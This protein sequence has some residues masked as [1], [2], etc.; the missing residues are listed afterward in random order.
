MWA[1]PS[2]DV[3]KYNVLVLHVKADAAVAD[4]GIRIR[5]T[6]VV[7]AE[8]RI[9]IGT[10]W[11]QIII[12]IIDLVPLNEEELHPDL[13]ILQ[14]VFMIFD[15]EKTDPEKGVVYIDL[16]GFNFDATVS[17]P[18][19]PLSGLSDFHVFPN[20]AKDYVTVR[21][22]AGDVI[23][24]FDIRGNLISSKTAPGDDTVI[25]LSG[26]ARGMYLIRVT[27]NNQSGTR[28]LIVY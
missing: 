12:P 18:E 17:V 27:G 21:T 22:N 24:L 4:V 9:D 13:T 15:H 14:G 3:S 16:V 19:I 11:Q 26:L 20:P 25:D 8:T 1:F 2:A 10:E 28:K 23:S 7:E 6:Q 5:D